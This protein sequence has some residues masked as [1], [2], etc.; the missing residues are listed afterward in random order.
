[1]NK[2]VSLEYRLCFLQNNHHTFDLAL[3]LKHYG[4]I[5]E[6]VYS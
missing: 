4:F 5:S 3:I 1:M 2:I 6:H